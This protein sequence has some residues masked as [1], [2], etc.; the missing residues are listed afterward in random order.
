[1]KRAAENE[2]LGSTGQTKTVKS[3][4]ATKYVLVLL[5]DDYFDDNDNDFVY[6]QNH[7]VGAVST[8][9]KNLSENHIE[10]LFKSTEK[11]RRED[12][13]PGCLSGYDLGMYDDSLVDEGLALR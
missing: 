11:S 7:L 6:H 4:S 12:K 2:A 3:A 1:M 8:A 13:I 9:R 10:S 5:H